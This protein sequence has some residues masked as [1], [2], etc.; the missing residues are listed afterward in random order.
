MVP[1][2]RG[3]AA[4]LL[5][6][7]GLAAVALWRSEPEPRSTP[8]APAPAV[9][10]AVPPPPASLDNDSRQPL[11]SPSEPI[12]EPAPLAPAASPE[13]DPERF[14]TDW[15]S[16]IEWESDTSALSGRVV[17]EREPLEGVTVQLFTGAGSWPPATPPPLLDTAVTDA[18]GRFRWVGLPA[19]RYRL[20]AEHEGHVVESWGAKLDPTRADRVVY[21]VFGSSS[22][23]GRV[24]DEFGAPIPA[25]E[26][27]ITGHGPAPPRGQWT[28]TDAQGRF[29]CGGL[30]AGKYNVQVSIAEDW[31]ADHERII[32]IGHAD[33]AVLHFGSAGP[34]GHWRGT[35]VNAEGEPVVGR[36]RVE[37][38]HVQRRDRLRRWTADDGSFEWPLGPGT[39][40]VFV[41]ERGHRDKPVAQL[42]M[43]D[44]NLDRN[45]TLPGIH[46]LLQLTRVGAVRRPGEL[47]D[48]LAG[49][50]AL[51]DESDLSNDTCEGAGPDQLQWIGQ[52]PGEFIFRIN[53]FPRLAD[54]ERPTRAGPTS[55]WV[56]IE[57]AETPLVQRLHLRVTDDPYPPR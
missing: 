18:D 9:E 41:D 1:A 12:P 57:V 27:R 49:E 17:L 46:V 7:L 14:Q 10:S 43:T 6:V 55:S 44:A 39:W 30:V 40:R 42:E 53:G 4:L 16:T 25:R 38:E 19:A 54:V 5:V 45:L 56:R 47:A 24:R 50:V 34:E 8:A 26:V 48:D 23:E 20:R 15:L 31:S 22:I 33:R 51:F 2:L 21:L 28:V 3:L 32:V 52:E 36:R 13:P 35:C 11:E 37:L 29:R